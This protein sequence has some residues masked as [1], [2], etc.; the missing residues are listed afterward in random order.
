MFSKIAIILISLR[1][2]HVAIITCSYYHGNELSRNTL[3]SLLP[4]ALVLS[5]SPTITVIEGE[6]VQITCGPLGPADIVI[7]GN[8][9]PLPLPFQDVNMQRVFTFGPVER[10]Q[11]GTVFQCFSGAVMTNTAMLDVLCKPITMLRY[12]YTDGQIN[13][14]GNYYAKTLGNMATVH[15]SCNEAQN[16]AQ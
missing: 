2:E 4:A 16:G 1:Y 13:A 14:L 11:Q 10:S 7:E 15:S 9:I 8:G 6:T 12:E 3:F 5:P